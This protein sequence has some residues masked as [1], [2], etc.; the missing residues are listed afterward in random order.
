MGQALKVVGIISGGVVIAG[1]AF[2]YVWYIKLD[3][4]AKTHPKTLHPQFPADLKHVQQWQVANHNGVGYTTGQEYVDYTTDKA[5]S[6]VHDLLLIKSSEVQVPSNALTVSL[7][8]E[9]FEVGSW[10]QEFIPKDFEMPGNA[11]FTY[12]MLSHRT[13]ATLYNEGGKSQLAGVCIYLTAKD[14]LDYFLPS[15]FRDGYIALEYVKIQETALMNVPFPSAPGSNPPT[16]RNIKGYSRF[17][18]TAEQRVII[19]VKD[20]VAQ[21]RKLDC[22]RLVFNYTTCEECQNAH[23]SNKNVPVNYQ[24]GVY[25]RSIL[26]NPEI[27][28]QIL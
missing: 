18:T 21:H 12:Q 1:S 26:E 28:R 7:A 2:L 24:Q 20:G 25:S 23:S 27:S 5:R 17:C 4:I 15:L 9:N 10:C 22:H 8:A 6:K 19:E 14:H 3:K 13:Q 11:Y 16:F